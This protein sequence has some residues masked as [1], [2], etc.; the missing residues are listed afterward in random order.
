MF[1]NTSWI[2]NY[3]LSSD[4]FNSR[5]CSLYQKNVVKLY[6][7]SEKCRQIVPCIKRIP[8]NCSLYQKNAVKLFPVSEECHQILNL[9]SG[10]L[11]SVLVDKYIVQW[12]LL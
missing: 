3:L 2:L 11:G 6:P 10:I 5:K 4:Y 12:N 9:N 8:S 7:V 1:F